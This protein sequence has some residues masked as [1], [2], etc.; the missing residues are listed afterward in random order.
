MPTKANQN[1]KQQP[2]ANSGSRHQPAEAKTRQRRQKPLKKKAN[3]QQ[4]QETNWLNQNRNCDK[5]TYWCIACDSSLKTQPL[6]QVGSSTRHHW[7]KKSQKPLR[8]WLFGED[9]NYGQTGTTKS[10]AWLLPREF[11]SKLFPKGRRATIRD[12]TKGWQNLNSWAT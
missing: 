11:P 1:K 5:G 6:Q 8:G 10:M 7:T 12:C 4:L 9:F 2:P 3:S